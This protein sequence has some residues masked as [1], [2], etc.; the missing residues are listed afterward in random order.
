MDVNKK[1]DMQDACIMIFINFGF[2]SV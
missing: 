1:W 2:D